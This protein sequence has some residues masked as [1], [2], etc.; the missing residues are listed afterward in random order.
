MITVRA[1]GRQK[2]ME[3]IQETTGV[4]SVPNVHVSTQEPIRLIRDQLMRVASAQK[5][6]AQD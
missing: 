6:S 4:D 1:I 2:K 5:D 3:T